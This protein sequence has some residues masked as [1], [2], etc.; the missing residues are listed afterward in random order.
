[1]GLQSPA[2]LLLIYCAC[3]RNLQFKINIQIVSKGPWMSLLLLLLL[4]LLLSRFSCVRLC[5][6]P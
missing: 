1:M 4:L 5:A 6:T 3:N 2:Q